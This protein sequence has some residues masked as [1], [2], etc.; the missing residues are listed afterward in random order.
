MARGPDKL[1]SDTLWPAFVAERERLNAIDRWYRW[2]HD[3]PVSARQATREHKELAKRAQTPLGHLIVTAVAQELYVEGYR[4]AEDPEDKAPWRA[5]QMNGMDARQVPLHRAA[6]A[7][8]E[9]TNLVLPGKTTLGEDYAV[10]RPLSP[11]Q[12]MTFWADPAVDDW[13]HLL[14][15][16][17]PARVDGDPGWTLYLYDDGNEWRYTVKSDGSKLAYV[18][19]STHG[20]GVCPAVR[21]ANQMD[22]EGRHPGEI[23]PFVPMF[24]RID[25]TTFDRLLVQRYASW[26]VRTI[27]GMAKPDSDEDANRVALKLKVEDLLVSD[28]PDTKFGTLAETLPNGFIDATKFDLSLLSA[29]SQT[30]SYE[31]LGDLINLSAEAL[32]AA[33]ASL[34]RKADERKHSFGKSHEQTIRLCARIMGDYDAAQDW[35]AQV[36][37]KDTEGRS[38]GQ[39]ADA[40]GKLAQMLGVPVEMLWEKI[41]GWTQTDVERAKDMVAAGDPISAL[42]AELDRGL[43]SDPAAL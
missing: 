28:N 42:V 20:V 39:A 8:G 33:R 23:E 38:L 12:S 25:Q 13:P 21:Y 2:D 14:L 43:N 9:A 29:V 36:L 31:L 27:S 30:P 32:V 7:Y 34:A 11:R 17:E 16:V 35:S 3:E 5:W 10:I 41:P 40:L 6:L 26:K 24:G 18:E 22:L 19:R 37:W 4:R 1:I 15:R